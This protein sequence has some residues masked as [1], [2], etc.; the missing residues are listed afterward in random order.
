MATMRTEP[1]PSVARAVLLMYAGAVVS[2]ANFVIGLALQGEFRRSIARHSA[3]HLTQHQLNAAFGAAIVA[4]VLAGILGV[5][6]WLW[7]A[8]A[9][10]LGYQ[11]ARVTATVLF[12]ISATDWVV[13]LGSG[14]P[15][16]TKF[17]SLAVVGVGA[18]TII[19]LY[20]PDASAYFG[21]GPGAPAPGPPGCGPPGEEPTG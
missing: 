15:A 2:G 10:R 12:A 13:S 17:T 7:M 8:H 6:L 9:N 5:A 18:A 19:L 1:P 16:W 11:W 14:D 21:R 3:R 20:R 4:I